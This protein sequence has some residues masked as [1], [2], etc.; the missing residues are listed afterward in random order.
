MSLLFSARSRAAAAT[1]MSGDRVGSE[2]AYLFH[3]RRGDKRI[4]SNGRVPK[5]RPPTVSDRAIERART[6]QTDNANQDIDL[7]APNS[8]LSAGQPGSLYLAQHTP[9]NP[10]KE[11]TAPNTN[12]RKGIFLRTSTMHRAATAMPAADSAATT[13]SMGEF[14]CGGGGA[15]DVGGDA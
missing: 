11:L 4:Q 1:A 3:Q 10:M 2:E 7:W 8:Q 14:A 9:L 6:C 15:D 12:K 13:G 5:D